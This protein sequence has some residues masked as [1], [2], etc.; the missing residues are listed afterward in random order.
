M[1]NSITIQQIIYSHWNWN[2]KSVVVN[3][4]VNTKHL[5]SSL[6]KLCIII[7]FVT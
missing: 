2:R 3:M 1:T 4:T 7:I 6:R 5:P